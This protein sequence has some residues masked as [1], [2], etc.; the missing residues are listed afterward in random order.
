MNFNL[1]KY[2]IFITGAYGYIGK[3]ISA[4]L[5]EVGA[6]V[7]INGRDKKKLNDLYI[8]L[9][10]KN[11]KVSKA[12]FDIKDTIKVKKFFKKI[13]SLHVVINN[14]SSGKTKKFN[15]FNNEDY[16]NVYE[17]AVISVAN[18]MKY[19]EKSL[20]KGAQELGT[21]SV[22]NISSMYGKVSPDFSIYDNTK[23]F[24]PPYYGAAKAALAQYAKYAA[25]YYGRKRIRI[26]T[27]SLGAIPNTKIK[28]IDKNFLNRLKKK[29][30]LN[31]VGVPKDIISTILYLSSKHSSFVTGA[32][33]SVDGGWT[34]K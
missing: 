25:V 33:I 18:I 6:H 11:Y 14:A 1:N 30:P 3:E 9:K 10:N 17:V 29:I 34:A 32:N 24:N 12:L 22:I 4:R 28:K 21:S 23:M 31:R 26:N 2:N 13:K 7:Y 27:I 15:K 20:L 5:C 19:S 8:E 16:M